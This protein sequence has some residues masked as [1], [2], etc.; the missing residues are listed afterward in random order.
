[1]SPAYA[2]LR[3]LGAPCLVF[4]VAFV[5]FLPALKA[6]FVNWDDYDTSSTTRVSTVWAGRSS[7]GCGRA[8]CSAI[9]SR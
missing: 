9:G 7:S 3:R 8:P 6:D 2:A 4:A 5:T 1:M